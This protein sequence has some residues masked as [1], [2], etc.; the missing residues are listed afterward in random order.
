MKLNEIANIELDPTTEADLEWDR[1]LQ[2]D[3][4]NGRLDHLLEAL[5]AE[6]ADGELE[7]L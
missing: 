1:I 6:L 7:E 4:R 3:L 2:E 5:D